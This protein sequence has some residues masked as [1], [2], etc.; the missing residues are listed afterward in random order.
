MWTFFFSQLGKSQEVIDVRELI[1]SILIIVSI[2]GYIYV[3][4]LI[5][6]NSDFFC[7]IVFLNVNY[8][9]IAKQ[10]LKSQT[11][12]DRNRPFIAMIDYKEHFGVLKGPLTDLCARSRALLRRWN[13]T[14]G[15][16]RQPERG[17]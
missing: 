6:D 14:S 10:S 7:W 5:Q 4:K 9:K 16:L 2:P 3:I 12:K 13:F 15:Y 8:G 1:L 11:P 17:K